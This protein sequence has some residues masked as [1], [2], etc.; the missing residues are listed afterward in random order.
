MKLYADIQ[1]HTDRKKNSFSHVFFFSHNNLSVE[2]S[3]AFG[4][5]VIPLTRLLDSKS[6]KRFSTAQTRSLD[7]SERFT[8]LPLIYDRSHVKELHPS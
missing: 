5:N 6:N 8:G 1:T 3:Q 4:K 2:M 7:T